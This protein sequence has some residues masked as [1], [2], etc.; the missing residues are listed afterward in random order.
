MLKKKVIAVALGI[1]LVIGICI[2][3]LQEQKGTENKYELSE[4]QCIYNSLNIYAEE[5]LVKHLEMEENVSIY[6]YVNDMDM[7]LAEETVEK[8]SSQ[9]HTFRVY[10]LNEENNEIA[11]IWDFKDI[12]EMALKEDQ[13][14]YK[15][16][17]EISKDEDGFTQV[18]TKGVVPAY[19][20]IPVE[21][22]NQTYIWYDEDMNAIGESRSDKTGYLTIKM[23]SNVVFIGP[24]V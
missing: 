17:A 16:R 13:A 20:V 12:S 2:G 10:F 9:I 21:E 3:I 19:L 8:C 15:L 11:Y 18:K 1:V 6:A 22:S 4:E 5:Y 24:E 14:D 7:E 23:Y